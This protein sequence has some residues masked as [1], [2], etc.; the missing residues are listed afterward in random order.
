MILERVM[1]RFGCKRI[2]NNIKT[3]INKLMGLGMT[4]QNIAMV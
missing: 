4:M 2:L 1:R 3:E